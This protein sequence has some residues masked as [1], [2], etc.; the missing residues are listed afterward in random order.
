MNFKRK[1]VNKNELNIILSIFFLF[2]LF[3]FIS[4]FHNISKS[5]INEDIDLKI[6]SGENFYSLSD[7]FDI[8]N[9]FLKIYLKLNKPA[10][11]LQAGVY[12]LQAGDNLVSIIEKLQGK[13]YSEE[14]NLTLLEGWN[15]Y[16]IDSYLF[17]KGFINEGEFIEKTTNYSK[18]LITIYPFL[19]NSKTLE[20]F[21]YPDTYSIEKGNFDLDVFINRLLNNFDTKV[22]KKILFNFGNKEILDIINLSSI[23]EKE[24]RN[25]TEKAIVAGILKK[26]LEEN[27]YLGA[28][29]TVCYPHK[30]TRE[31]CTPSF[32]VNHIYEKNSYNT[33][34]LLGL[35]STP[36]SNPS[37]E[38]IEATINSKVTPYYYYLHD[39]DGKIH[40]ATTNL[41]HERNKALYLK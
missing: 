34:T 13:I 15:I 21:L 32:V 12:K 24:E 37:L 14:I 7:K 6:E 36:I 38:T 27:W 2:V 8:N 31:T 26:R 41:E 30:A 3:I 20:G 39:N 1:N 17:H 11:S 23:V 40:Y 18:N 22:Y 35:P 33:R 5:L 16:D 9:I 25:S 29:A 19:E 10:K 4:Y 28:D